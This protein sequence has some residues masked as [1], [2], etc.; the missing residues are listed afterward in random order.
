MTDISS[1]TDKKR[2]PTETD[3]Y[4]TLGENYIL[5]QKIKEYVRH[6][7]Q[8]AVGVWNYPGEK[9]GWNYRIKDNRRAIIYLLPRE[10][11]FKVA[12]VF[13]QRATIMVM[14]S[15]VS[16]EIKTVLDSAKP[17]VEGRGIRIDVHND[18]VI[19]DIKVLI[20]IKIAY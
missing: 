18:S 19:S 16:D 9:Y 4:Y 3:L 14:Q 2:V 5:W 15:N 13:G 7:Y 12:F 8:G 10:N 11:Y 17:Y 1:F 20:D 6:Q